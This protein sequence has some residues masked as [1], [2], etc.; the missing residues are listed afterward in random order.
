PEPRDIPLIQHV[1]FIA[2]CLRQALS[3]SCRPFSIQPFVGEF[4]DSSLRLMESKLVH[5]KVCLGRP[6]P[7]PTVIVRITCRVPHVGGMSL[8]RW[9]WRPVCLH[10]RRRHRHG[11]LLIRVPHHHLAVVVHCGPFL[12]AFRHHCRRLLP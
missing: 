7:Y 8:F 6:D 11:F 1:P 2:S 5:R 9:E 3:C 10:R 12:A 4:C